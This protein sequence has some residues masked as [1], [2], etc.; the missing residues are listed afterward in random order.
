MCSVVLLTIGPFAAESET[1][2]RSLAAS[3]VDMYRFARAPLPREQVAKLI[4]AIEG[5]HKP[6]LRAFF[7]HL[8]PDQH[9]LWELVDV[10]ARYSDLQYEYVVCLLFLL[11]I[12]GM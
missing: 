2:R 9:C 10:P 4:M 6:A 11:G 5:L 3:L 1:E 8:R 12:D 7:E